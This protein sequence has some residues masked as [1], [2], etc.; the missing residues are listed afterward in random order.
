[1]N[2]KNNKPQ[3]KPQ[4][5][6]TAQQLVKIQT[7]GPRHLSN[8][9]RRSAGQSPKRATKW[10]WGF[11]DK[12]GWEWLNL[13]VKLLV[14]LMIGALTITNALQQNLINQQQYSNN[15]M[16]S[17]DQQQATT[18]ATYLDTMK[19]LM[20]NYNL[21]QSKP[22]DE[23]RVVERV[24]TLTA[25]QRIDPNRKDIVLHFLFEAGLIQIIRLDDA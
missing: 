7:T 21:S 20:L 4:A 15:Q 14:P 22:N 6:Q 11:S 25:L 23:V 3:K 18:L 10:K 8:G 16:I 19:N 24:E 5:G 12:T 1:M 2:R 13:S 17:L 9:R